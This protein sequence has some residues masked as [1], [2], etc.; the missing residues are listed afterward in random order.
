MS[1]DTRDESITNNNASAPRREKRPLDRLTPHT[2]RL[3][4]RQSSVPPFDPAKKSLASCGDGDG[5]PADASPIKATGRRSPR[6]KL[7][8]DR[9]PR[10]SIVGLFSP[11]IS[12]RCA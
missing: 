6:G 2:M 3:F 9:P 10:L 7:L 5:D 11:E 8:A 12:H 4:Q 1:A